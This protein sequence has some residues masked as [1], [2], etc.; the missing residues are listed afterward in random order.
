MSALIKSYEDVVFNKSLLNKEMNNY[1]CLRV[2]RNNQPVLRMCSQLGYQP[3][4][5]NVFGFIETTVL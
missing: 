5:S 4:K 1:F 2:Q 3:Q